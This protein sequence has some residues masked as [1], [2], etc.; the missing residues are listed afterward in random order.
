MVCLCQSLKEKIKKVFLFSLYLKKFLEQTIEK[1]GKFPDQHLNQNIDS[2]LKNSGFQS[3]KTDL[4]QNQN[5]IIKQEVPSIIAEKKAGLLY[6]YLHLII[7]KICFKE[8]MFEFDFENF[9]KNNPEFS[10]QKPTKLQGQ[11]SKS[12]LEEDEIYNEFSHQDFNNFLFPGKKDNFKDNK[13]DN[14]PA[15]FAN[16]PGNE[17]NYFDYFPNTFQNPNVPQVNNDEFGPKLSE[18]PQNYSQFFADKTIE[19]NFKNDRAFDFI[20]K[21]GENAFAGNLYN[22]FGE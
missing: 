13:I 10:E 16:N 19:E 9:V 18:I 21:D 6:F 2:Q 5:K 8:K 7:I 22:F 3:E 11:Q 12:L 20:K 15:F 17:Q 4:A 1:K 14:T